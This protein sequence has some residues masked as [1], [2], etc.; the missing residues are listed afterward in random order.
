MT[1]LSETAHELTHTHVRRTVTEDGPVYGDEPPLLQILAEAVGAS[2][3]VK[4]GGTS[5]TG[6]PIDLGAL[7]LWENIRRTIDQCWPGAGDPAY[8][9]VPS[10]VKLNAW[11]SVTT[12]PVAEAVLLDLCT[13]WVGQIREHLEPT[14][15]VPLGGVACPVCGWDR[16]VT[17][18]E[19]G[20]TYRPA[21]V[22]FPDEQPI[23]VACT[24]EACGREWCGAQVVD[25]F[26][27]RLSVVTPAV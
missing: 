24:V 23:R 4:A 5:K 20:F 10:H 11:V 15:R 27:H 14:K 1:L 26:A 9:R 8:V 18:G 21:L 7:D 2:S 19:D 17:E 3:Q 13:R 6:V 16:T 25:T 22:A 12:D